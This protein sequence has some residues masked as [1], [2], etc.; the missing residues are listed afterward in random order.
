MTEERSISPCSGKYAAP[1]C[2]RQGS[3]GNSEHEPGR[4]GVSFLAL[5][6][7]R[8]ENEQIGKMYIEI[9]SAPLECNIGQNNNILSLDFC[10]LSDVV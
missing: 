9:K 3:H 1:K 8:G 7:P 10:P 5:I 2:A 4:D 6:V